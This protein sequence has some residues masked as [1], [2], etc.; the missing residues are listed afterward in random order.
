[1]I[2]APRR[3]RS[4]RE[5][6]FGLNSFCILITVRTPPR[7]S[8]THVLVSEVDFG[9]P[10]AIMNVRGTRAARNRP[11]RCRWVRRSSTPNTSNNGAAREGR[12]SAGRTGRVLPRVSSGMPRP[13]FNPVT[14]SERRQGK[15]V[16]A[17]NLSRRRRTLSS[18]TENLR[19]TA[20]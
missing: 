7:P 2:R 16:W 8:L 12:S 11:R 9:R 17:T 20:C 18:E 14:G 10:I 4:G 3:F 19:R 13:A 1:M 5:E 6:S 15:R